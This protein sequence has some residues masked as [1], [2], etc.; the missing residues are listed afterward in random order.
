MEE[1]III[2]AN[3]ALSASAG[4]IIDSTATPKI[5]GHMTIAGKVYTTIVQTT[6]TQTTTKSD[7][8]TQD[9]AIKILQ[10]KSLNNEIRLNLLENEMDDLEKFGEEQ[11]ERNKFQIMMNYDL[12]S[13]I[14]NPFLWEAKVSPTGLHYKLEDAKKEQQSYSK[15]IENRLLSVMDVLGSQIKN[16][17]QQMDMYLF[18]SN[19]T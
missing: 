1:K 19:E 18:S 14:N 16:M 7:T 6:T 3:T 15:A 12:L 13:K 4:S 17:K 5:T 8:I 11:K 9:P 2:A 10:E